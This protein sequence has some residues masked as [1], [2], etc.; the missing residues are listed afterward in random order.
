M[1]KE[2]S[3]MMGLMKNLPKLQAS[4]QEMQEK[5]ARMSF[6]GNA[7]AGMVVATVNGRMELLRV[8]ISDDAMKLNDKEM[9]A[10]LVVAAVNM[11]MNKAREEAAKATATMAQDTGIPLPQ[12][13]LEGLFGS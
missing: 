4:M 3:Q 9:L 8:A 11:A 12:G 10:D 6:D 5:L 7:G 2:L 1:I 13:G